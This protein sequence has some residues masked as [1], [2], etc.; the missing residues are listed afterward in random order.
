M[1]R[2]CTPRII[3]QPSR[4]FLLSTMRRRRGFPWETSLELSVPYMPTAA[5]HPNHQTR[6]HA[7]CN[8]CSVLK[9]RPPRDK[10][11]L[12]LHQHADRPHLFSVGTLSFLGYL[13]QGTASTWATICESTCKRKRTFFLYIPSFMPP[14][15]HHFEFSVWV[16]FWHGQPSCGSTELGNLVPGSRAVHDPNTIPYLISYVNQ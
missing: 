3:K 15:S 9:A 11:L 10:S 7:S 8:S 2:M 16:S 6:S 12:K 5:A 13:S 4:I 14:S 1:V